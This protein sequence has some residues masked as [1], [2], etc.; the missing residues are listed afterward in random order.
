MPSA[1]PVWT[2]SPRRA[3]YTAHWANTTSAQTP[4]SMT[5]VG[6]SGIVTP[7]GQPRA[8]GV[9]RPFALQDPDG[10]HPADEHDRGDAGQRRAD[11]DLAAR[12]RGR[13]GGEGVH[14]RVRSVGP[15]VP[16]EVVAPARVT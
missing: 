3:A 7:C 4:M 6:T 12:R 2:L 11:E 9:E 15:E 13:S 1:S 16:C 8:L 14:Q 10:E 5:F